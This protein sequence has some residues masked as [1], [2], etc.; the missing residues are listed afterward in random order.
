VRDHMP[1]LVAVN[2]PRYGD[3]YPVDTPNGMR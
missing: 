1:N 2:F 3:L